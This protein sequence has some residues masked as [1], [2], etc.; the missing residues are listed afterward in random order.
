MIEPKKQIV[1]IV[2]DEPEIRALYA[3]KITDAGY[4]VLTAQDGD[5]GFALALEKHP[6]IILLDYMLPKMNGLDVLKQL[7]A[8][9]DWGKHVPTI[10][11]TNINPN[12]EMYKDIVDTTPTY[13]L[14]KSNS[15]PEDIVTKIQ[16]RLSETT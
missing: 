11:L 14:I 16:E 1:L 3:R 10:M 4:A 9:D 8:H 13:Y 15:S 6:N 2:E 5:E 7:R 12:N